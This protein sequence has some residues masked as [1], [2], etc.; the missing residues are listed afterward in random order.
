MLLPTGNSLPV[1]WEEMTAYQQMVT[2][3]LFFE[4]FGT[5]L[6]SGVPIVQAMHTVAD[7]LPQASQEGWTQAIRLVYPNGEPF[8]P[9]MKRMGIFPDIAVEMIR[10]GE[11]SGSLDTMMHRLAES[12]E[13]DLEY[14][15]FIHHLPFTGI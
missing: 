3:S 2:L 7:L 1:T 11:E 12:F 8:S 13:A 14:H 5:L 6:Q 9:E 10:I 4:A 15:T